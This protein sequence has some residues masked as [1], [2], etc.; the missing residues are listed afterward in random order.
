MAR[1]HEQRDDGDNNGGGSLP[2]AASA[3]RASRQGD[4]ECDGGKSPPSGEGSAFAYCCCCCCG[5]G[6]SGGRA[7]LTTSDKSC[8]RAREIYICI[9]RDVGRAGEERSGEDTI[10]CC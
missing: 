4:I 8:A 10:C 7:P 6:G 9:Y 2:V 3:G 1:A 5:S